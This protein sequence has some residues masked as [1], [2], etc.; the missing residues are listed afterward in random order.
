MP[1][2]PT[3]KPER[4]NVRTLLRCTGIAAA[5]LVATACGGGN[6]GAIHEVHADYPFYSSAADLTQ[7]SDVVVT[8][9]ARK[10]STTRRLIP[11]GVNVG[12]LPEYKRAELGI[13]VTDVEY[14]VDRIHKGAAGATIVV[15][16]IG[17]Q[18]GNSR[19]VD[20]NEPNS[21]PGQTMLLFLRRGADGSYS[22]VGGPQGRYLNVG[23]RA[24]GL[25][26]EGVPRPLEGKSATTPNLSDTT[27][28]RVAQDNPSPAPGNG[29]KPAIPVA[30]TGG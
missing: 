14:A 17:G 23:G 30:P 26:S 16:E 2:T 12:A 13:V 19:Y 15:T 5:V 27:P 6:G 4:S 8:A 21:K 7:A 18:I 10:A 25:G 22:V 3:T 9:T 28:V 1:S 24:K 29:G 20:E 11:E